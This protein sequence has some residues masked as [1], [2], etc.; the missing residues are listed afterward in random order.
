MR[1]PVDGWC[2]GSTVLPVAFRCDGRQILLRTG[3]G[4]KLEA[5]TDNAVVAFE[6]DELH[7]GSRS[8]WSV[9]VTGV[10]RELTEPDELTAARRLPLDRWIEGVD[11]PIVAISL[12]LV[13]GRR[14]VPR[15][16]NRR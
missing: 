6:V 14:L 4:S 3:A 5:D 15:P 2:H 10:A 7:P 12:D 16:E 9:V 8:G 13:S 1:S 11:G